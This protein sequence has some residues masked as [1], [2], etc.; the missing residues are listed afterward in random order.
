MP[1]LTKTQTKAVEEAED[2]EFVLL[3][4][5]EYMGAL[6]DVTVK[7]GEKGPYWQWEF[8][9]VEDADG[10]EI[11]QPY[12][13]LWENTSLSEG[14]AFRLKAMFEA[15]G[16]SADTDTDDLLNQ[17]VVIQVGQEVQAR[18]SNAGKLRNVFLS[19]SPVETTD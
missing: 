7:T 3:P 17:Y 18:G 5:G 14:A 11:D 8:L 1:K 15:F 2:R 16:V 13:K 19:A 9:L 4:A 12:P 10:E 6:N